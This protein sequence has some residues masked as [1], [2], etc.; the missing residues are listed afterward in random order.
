MK[1]VLDF[2]FFFG[3]CF[4]VN[5]NWEGSNSETKTLKLINVLKVIKMSSLFVCLFHTRYNSHV[6][7]GF[8]VSDC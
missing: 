4:E 3:G 2:R 7:K 1:A 8:L 6:F 5:D